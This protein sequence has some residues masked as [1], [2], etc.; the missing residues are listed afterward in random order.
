MP[1]F[2]HQLS[3]LLLLFLAQTLAVEVDASRLVAKVSARFS[4][5]EASAGDPIYLGV[6]LLSLLPVDA[7]LESLEVKMKKKKLFRAHKSC[8]CYS[9][10]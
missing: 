4:T 1:L 9:S 8:T 10:F 5:A 2:Q 6:A 3:L 7:R